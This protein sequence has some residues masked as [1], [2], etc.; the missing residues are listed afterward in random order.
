MSADAPSLLHSLQHAGNM[1]FV[2][3][4]SHQS[5]L[6]LQQIHFVIL[7]ASSWTRSISDEGRVPDIRKIIIDLMKRRISNFRITSASLLHGSAAK[8]NQ[9]CVKIFFDAN[10]LN[11]VR[12]IILEVLKEKI[13]IPSRYR[14]ICGGRICPS[15]KPPSV[16][17]N[18]CRVIGAG[19]SPS[20]RLHQWWTSSNTIYGYIKIK[21]GAI[22]FKPS[23]Q[24]TEIKTVRVNTGKVKVENTKHN[25][26][27]NTE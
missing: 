8:S 5:R 11:G 23:G 25:Q 17:L 1:I 12:L 16:R 19:Q 21:G 20:C 13:Q 14:G 27:L 3:I 26:I 2:G 4:K 10:K 24:P 15:S 9:W 22:H 18:F 7:H 6:L